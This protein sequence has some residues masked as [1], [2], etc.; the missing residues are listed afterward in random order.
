M[1]KP[2]K[3]PTSGETE[4]DLLKLQAEFLKQKQDRMKKDVVDINTKMDQDSPATVNRKRKI[5][6][7]VRSSKL[8]TVHV[9]WE[10]GKSFPML[11]LQQKL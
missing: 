9:Q 3:R 4:E 1:S 8:L 11:S 2:I 10:V 7:E 5:S 6:K